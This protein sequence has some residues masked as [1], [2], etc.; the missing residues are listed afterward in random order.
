MMIAKLQD[1]LKA[2]QLSK[3][4]LKV[5][6]LRLLL[7]EIHNLEILL[8]QSSG[9]E[10]E[11]SEEDIISVVQREAK[12]RKEALE[13]FRKGG[14]EVK[15]QQEETELKILAEYLPAQMTNEELT[16]VIDQAKLELGAKSIADLG[17]VMAKVMARVAGRADGSLVSSLVRQKLS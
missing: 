16:Q 1:D 3:N 4:E 15:A 9:Q 5:S 6:T 17:K 2:A 14:R 8:R 12:K 7:S 10:K 11:I 13:A